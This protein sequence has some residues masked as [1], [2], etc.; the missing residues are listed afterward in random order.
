[1]TDDGN[2]FPSKPGW[3]P[4]KLAGPHIRFKERLEVVSQSDC[5]SNDRERWVGETAGGEDGGACQIEVRGAEHSSVA[6]DDTVRSVGT[7]PSRP[8]V[9]IRINHVTREFDWIV[10]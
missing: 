3:E 6:I 1:M 9:M 2:V 10:R 8:H 4:S 7:H 5:K